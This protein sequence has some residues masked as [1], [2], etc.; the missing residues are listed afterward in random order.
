FGGGRIVDAAKMAAK[1]SNIPFISV[2]TAI[3]HDGIASNRAVLEIYSAPAVMPTGILVDSDIIIKSPYRLT[4]A[5]FGDMV[6]K[7]TAVEDWELSNDEIG[8]YI[9]EYAATINRTAADLVIRSAK[10]IKNLEKKGLENLIEALVFS[11]IAMAIAG[12]SRPAS[13]SEHMFSHALKELYPK[14]TSLHGEEC[15]VGSILCSYLHNMDWPRIVEAL[16]V[17]GAPTNN[18]ELKIPREII[19]KALSEAKNIRKDRYTILDYKDID[20]KKAEIAAKETG[21]IE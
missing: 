17:V 5:G 3:S 9:S 6:S 4:A 10:S 20:E 8:E 19:I 2:P 13:G 15:A 12:S 16:K 7:L 21:V 11:G 18:E 1:K 14:K